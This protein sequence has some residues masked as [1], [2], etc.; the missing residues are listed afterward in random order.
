MGRLVDQAV[1]FYGSTPRQEMS[2]NA[3]S[4]RASNRQFMTLAFRRF[5][6][7]CYRKLAT[8]RL[9]QTGAE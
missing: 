1:L 6:A 2:H 7:R 8:R 5:I 3:D 9:P 4:Y